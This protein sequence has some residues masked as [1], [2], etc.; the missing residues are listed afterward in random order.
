MKLSTIVTSLSV[1]AALTLGAAQFASAARQPDKDPKKQPAKAPPSKDVAPAQPDPK[2]ME[3]MMKKMGETGPEHKV[4]ARMVGS[5]DCNVKFFEPD[6][7]GKVVETVSKGEAKFVS[8]LGGR[9]IRQDFKSE[10]DKQPFSG[11]GYSGY[12][13]NKSQYCGT[14]IDTMSTSMM[15]MT[16]TYD[17]AKKTLTET[18]TMSMMGMD[19]KFRHTSE[20]KDANTVVFSMYHDMGEGEV[21]AM[22]ITYKRRG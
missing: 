20:E 19:I 4:L 11:I 9:W 7:T 10:F 2:A 21:K 17:E 5:W 18:G 1:A 12:D 15:T 14:W 13:K 22:E 8:E 6:A 3:E 16:G